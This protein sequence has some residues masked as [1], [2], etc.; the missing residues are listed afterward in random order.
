MSSGTCTTENRFLT[1]KNT[2]FFSL[3]QVSGV[4]SSIFHQKSFSINS[5]WV[6]IRI[7]AFLSDSDPAKTCGFFRNPN[8]NHNNDILTGKCCRYI[9]YKTECVI[10]IM[11][12]YQCCGAGTAGNYRYFIWASETFWLQTWCTV[13]H[14]QILKKAQTVT[15]SSFSYCS[16]VQPFQ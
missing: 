3:F 11:Y 2:V 16:R 12:Q 13:Q 8:R 5:V 9:V 14:R 1:E 6:P 7:Q 4:W 15:V 10:N